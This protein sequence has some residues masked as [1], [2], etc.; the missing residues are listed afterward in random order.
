MRRGEVIEAS[1]LTI[2]LDATVATP[3][4]PT[5]PPP[6]FSPNFIADALPAQPSQFI[7]AWHQICWTVYLHNHNTSEKIQKSATYRPIAKSFQLQ[8][9]DHTGNTVPSIFYQCLL[10]R[11][12]PRVP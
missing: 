7:L 5:I 6:P 2:R 9:L 3:S 10:L 12:Q 1:A 8:A 4:G 11:T